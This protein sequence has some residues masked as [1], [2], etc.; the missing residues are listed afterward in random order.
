M[1]IANTQTI[2][3]SIKKF[4]SENH[5]TATEIAKRSGIH[6][7]SLSRLLSGK[8]KVIQLETLNKLQDIGIYVQIDP[9]VNSQSASVSPFYTALTECCADLEELKA[10]QKWMQTPAGQKL[11]PLGMYQFEAKCVQLLVYLQRKGLLTSNMPE[12]PGMPITAAF[13]TP[14]EDIPRKGK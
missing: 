2:R 8:S 13:S 12:L 1:Y 11:F 4:A 6:I 3:D 14:I 9:I 10:I 7:T 5:L